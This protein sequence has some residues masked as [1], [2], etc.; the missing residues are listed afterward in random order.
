[1]RKNIEQKYQYVSN[2]T[3]HYHNVYS[4][5]LPL[6]LSLSSSPSP[7]LPLLL[8]LLLPLPPQVPLSTDSV[9]ASPVSL[10]VKSDDSD[11]VALDATEDLMNSINEVRLCTIY[12]HVICHFHSQQYMYVTINYLLNLISPKIIQLANIL[13]F[14]NHQLHC[15][16]N[17]VFNIIFIIAVYMLLLFYYFNRL[18][19]GYLL[20]MVLKC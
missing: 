17:N 4:L 13:F 9:T 3:H 16:F 10:S 15:T 1:M 11:K 18:R 2:H 5:L 19:G 20:V 8:F 14:K 6:L 12:V 7:P